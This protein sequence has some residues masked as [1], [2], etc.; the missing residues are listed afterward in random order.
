MNNYFSLGID[1]G[2]T[3]ICGAVVDVKNNLLI[4]SFEKKN[5]SW[6]D[7]GV[8]KTQDTDIIL[9][10]VNELLT[11]VLE[12]YNISNIGFTGQMHGIVYIDKEGFAVSPLYT[13][14]NEF[15]NQIISEGNITYCEEIANLTGHKLTTGYGFST[16]FYL[17]RNAMIA[18]NAKSFCTIMDYIAMRLCGINKPLCHISNAASF[19]LF[20]IKNNKFDFDAFKKI[21]FDLELPSLTSNCEVIGYYKSI[22]V[23]NA[24]GD[25][26]ASVLATIGTSSDKILVNFGTG[27]Q[28]SAISTNYLEIEGLETRP[29][30]NDNYLLVGSALCGGRAYAIIERFFR[31]YYFECFGENVSQYEIMN[32]LAKAGYE[33]KSNMKV[34]TQFCGNRENTDIYGMIENITDSNFLPSN[35][36]FGTILGMVNELYNMYEKMNLKGITKA[37]ASGNAVKKNSVLLDTIKDVFMLDTSVMD[38]DEEAA[39]GAAIFA[40]K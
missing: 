11:C 21:S 29:Y 13:W 38:Y 12:K 37:V 22:P 23:Y 31:E 18:S 34:H 14:Q 25:N 19:G 32:K 26:Q 33:N 39:F 1:I 9:S 20:D 7:K 8:G 40:Q 24:I 4:E 28:I 6:I 27:S 35:V 5:D 30:L 36:I 15:G 3:T 10:V 16:H 17:Q 2:T